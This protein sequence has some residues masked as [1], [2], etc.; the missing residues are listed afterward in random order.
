[1]RPPAIYP[2][3][4][5]WDAHPNLPVESFNAGLPHLRIT[6][7][8]SPTE[9]MRLWKS[10]RSTNAETYFSQPR[11]ALALGAGFLAIFIALALLVPTQPLAIEQHWASWMLEAQSPL[12]TK[13]A[14]VFNA[15]GRG[16]GRT[17]VLVGIG[18]VLIAARRWW[19]LLAYAV[20]EAL[21]PL[22]TTLV[23]ELVERPRPPDGLVHPSGASFPSGHASFAG[24]TC[25]ALVVMFTSPGRRRRLWWC[26]A[27]VGIAGM[28]WSRTYLQ[29]HWLLDVLAGS[30]LGVSTAL[31][32]YAAL[33]LVRRN[34]RSAEG[35]PDGSASSSRRSPDGRQR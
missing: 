25:L 9:T 13:I 17:L 26:L 1:M 30:L 21:T 5:R 32:G 4:G 35:P 14:H 34:L 33:Q 11:Q 31:V 2:A 28:A 8:L 10:E 24:A 19:A 18:V 29:V 22:F 16:L 7:S 20:V 23:K 15:L 12:L 6:P 3:R 27:A